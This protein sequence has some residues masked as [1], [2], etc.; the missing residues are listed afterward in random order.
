M[1]RENGTH[2]PGSKGRETMGTFEDSYTQATK[3][4]KIL[5]ELNKD[6]N[7]KGDFYIDADGNKIPLSEIAFLGEDLLQK[8]RADIQAEIDKENSLKAAGK[9]VNEKLLGG[10]LKKTLYQEDR[11]W[12][13][14]SGT[15]STHDNLK[16][17]S[18]AKRKEDVR[19]TRKAF[20][21]VGI[22]EEIEA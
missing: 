7:V 9:D 15:R 6:D 14:N 21:T 19:K 22:E 20:E 2:I 18:P 3:K 5:S 10:K 13:P 17:E 12:D 16:T 1:L 8:A 11:S 4:E